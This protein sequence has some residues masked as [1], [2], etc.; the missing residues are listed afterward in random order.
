[1]WRSRWSQIPRPPQ[2]FKGAWNS[3]FLIPNLQNWSGNKMPQSLSLISEWTGTVKFPRLPC[4]HGHQPERQGAQVLL[5]AAFAPCIRIFKH[6]T[7]CLF[8]HLILWRHC[9]KERKCHLEHE[10]WGERQEMK[11]H[12]LF[13]RLYSETAVQACEKN[14][15]WQTQP[16]AN[17]W[18]YERRWHVKPGEEAK[19]EISFN[20]AHIV[21]YLLSLPEPSGLPHFQGKKCKAVWKARSRTPLLVRLLAWSVGTF[22][23]APSVGSPEA[24]RKTVSSAT[25]PPHAWLPSLPL[26][27]PVPEPLLLYCCKD[28]SAVAWHL[29][30]SRS[31]TVFPS[32][33]MNLQWTDFLTE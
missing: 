14:E 25:D 27:P 15:P 7:P 32:Q 26:L 20:S 23:R 21:D 16:L 22:H 24:V 12:C 6:R 13:A 4:Y 30:R 3:R 8:P 17:R 5:W 2:G 11:R 33:R 19:E 29:Q 18:G 31:L 1:M 9:E 28:T 10:S